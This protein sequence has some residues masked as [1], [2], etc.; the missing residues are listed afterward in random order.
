MPP[1][2]TTSRPADLGCCS[3]DFAS[4]EIDPR[5]QLAVRAVS[6]TGLLTIIIEFGVG[7]SVFEFLAMPSPDS[8]RLGCWWVGLVLMFASAFGLLARTKGHLMA[9]AVLSAIGV[10]IAM[11]GAA[12]DGTAFAG[13]TA[14]P[15]GCAQLQSWSPGA[16]WSAGLPGAGAGV[17]VAARALLRKA[18]TAATAGAAALASLHT[19][20]VIGAAADGISTGISIS[21]SS[22]SGSG[23]SSKSSGPPS[24]TFGSPGSDV[25]KLVAQQ[26][27]YL[28]Y[29]QVRFAPWPCGCGAILCLF[30]SLN[31]RIFPSS[32]LVSAS[33]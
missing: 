3:H 10:P 15:F 1:P 17:Q 30:L 23:S 28:A 21:S 19:P 11:G 33:V 14:T 31:F 16:G 32:A 2:A 18:A 25:Q 5:L 13:F 29:T 22:G 9:A 26:C 7:G 8:V 20:D 6:A 12:A 27:L 4:Q 24:D